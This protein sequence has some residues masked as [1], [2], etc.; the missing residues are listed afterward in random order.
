MLLI[1]L[2]DRANSLWA[3]QLAQLIDAES[4]AMANISDECIQAVN[5]TV[6]EGVNSTLW[7]ILKMVDSTGKVPAGLF[8]GNIYADGAYDECFSLDNTAYCTGMVNI[9]EEIGWKFGM[10]VPRGCNGKDIA[11]VVNATGVLASNEQTSYCLNTKSP[12]FNAGAIIMITVCCLFGLMVILGSLMHC[13][14]IY[15]REGLKYFVGKPQKSPK[16]VAITEDLQDKKEINISDH[17]QTS[18]LKDTVEKEEK[19]KKGF[20]PMEFIE[21]FSVFKN[22]PTILSTK[23]PPSA[24]TSLNGLRVISMFWVILGHTHLW[25]LYSTGVDNILELK[26]VLSRFSF[27]AVGNAYFAVDSFFFLSGLLVAYLTLR[28]MARKKGRF[29]FLIYYVHRYLRL[30]P[31]YA[32][33]IFFF[34]LMSMH[35]ADGPSYF[36]ITGADS[37]QYK[38]CAKYW[39][40]NLLYIS[41]LYPWK[42]RDECIAWSWYLAND[43]QFFTITPLIL[44]PMY[45]LLPLGL[46]LISG[47]LFVSFLITAALTRVFDL[48]ANTFAMAAYDYTTNVTVTAQDVLYTKPW[49][50]ISPYLV[51]L[52]LGYLLYRNAQIPFKRAVNL[53]IYLIMWLIAAGILMSCLYGLYLTWHGHTPS[54][55]ENI[56]YN[57]FSRFAWGVSLALIVFACHNGY[58]WVINS[59]LSMK[60]WIPLSRLS[61]NAYLFHPLV[62]SAVIGS[63]RKSIHYYD[64]N[65]AA[66]AI[67]N[68]VLS[69]GA[70]ALV[71][72]LVEF[73]LGNIEQAVFKMVG[74]GGRESTRSG[75]NFQPTKRSVK[76]TTEEASHSTNVN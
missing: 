1:A 52:V 8:Q 20:K 30:T 31:A 63:A 25:V 51:G 55:F 49:H 6:N 22:I 44:I 74:L 18:L 60:F 34:W 10:C 73:P 42:L 26:N 41:N 21:A 43:M 37:F 48:Q 68:V 71:A 47:F 36:Q 72:V 4:A 2:Y 17:D 61:Y 64:I 75:T 7:T 65:M 66:F 70:A 19:P 5:E 28:Q 76:Q 13:I 59:F 9:T 38:A 27:Q 69:Y 32:F 3:D 57:T 24:I 35:L 12:P 53:I 15:R 62:V 33:V 58:G 14:F 11:I 16:M 39:W 46:I 29:P 23:Q 45:H 67:A 50:R 54:L 56:I 40:T